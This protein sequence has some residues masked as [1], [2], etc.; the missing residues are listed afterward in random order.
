VEIDPRS[1]EPYYLQ[2]ADIIRGRIESGRY[3][4]G[5]LIPSIQR[6]HQETGLSIMTIRHGV[7]IVADEGFIQIVPG[8]GTYVSTRDQW[9]SG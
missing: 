4:P 9:P 5:E 1:P 6:I 3:K 8:K 2:L 7:R